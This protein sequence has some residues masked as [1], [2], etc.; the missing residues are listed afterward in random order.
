M[1][2]TNPNKEKFEQLVSEYNEAR[3]DYIESGNLDGETFYIFESWRQVYAIE[4]L[5]NDFE[6]LKELPYLREGCS[7]ADMV[8]ALEIAVKENP[9]HYGYKRQLHD[10]R[11]ALLYVQHIALREK[12]GIEKVTINDCDIEFGFSNKYMMCAGQC[13][14]VV[15]TSPDCYSWTPPLY[16]EAEG[17]VC[18]ECV[19]KGDYDEYVLEQYAN[20][21]KSIPSQFSMSK[22]GLVR[23]NEESFENGLYGGQMDEPKPIIDA[24]NKAGIDCWFKVYPSQFDMD[25]DVYVKEDNLERAKKI[26]SDTNTKAKEDPAVLLDRGLKAAS[27]Q[28]SKLPEGQGIK[29]SS[30]DMSNGTATSRI[31]SNEEFIRGIKE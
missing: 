24:L 20:E 3:N 6:G 15:R 4:G 31:V 29:Y 11:I 13:G 25:F 16:I 2:E 14:N 22:L 10:A 12:E 9:D 28:M 8:S 30:I 7:Y 21:Q 5:L 19:A 23:V 1:E 27:E 26:L 18:D 17:Y